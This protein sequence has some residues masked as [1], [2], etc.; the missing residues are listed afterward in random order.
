M[1]TLAGFTRPADPIVAD[2][3]AAQITAAIASPV[4]ATVVSSSEVAVTGAVSESNRVAIQAAISAYSYAAPGA[5]TKAAVGLG[6]VDNTADIDKPVSTATQA[7]LNAKASLA[8]P[9]FTGTATGITAAMVGAPSGSGTSTG[10]NTGDQSLAGL[11][12]TSRTVAGK[13]LSADV[14]L[15]KADVGLGNVDNTSDASKPVSTAA[16]TALNAKQGIGAAAAPATTGAMTV[17]MTQT[18]VTVTPTG[19]C[20]FN[21]SGGAIGARMTFVVTTSGASSFVLTF[22]TNFK[23]A[24]TLATGTVTAKVFCVSFTCKDGT[25]WVETGRTAAM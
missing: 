17:P 13:P 12:P 1:A 6:S 9:A 15:A 21:A 18:V 7:A 4:T 24:G 23:A 11:V 20:T 2:D 16:Q 19:A 5:L 22:G 3:L 14:S 25:L 8:S 10:A